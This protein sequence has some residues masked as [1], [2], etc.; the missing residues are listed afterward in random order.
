MFIRDVI[1]EKIRELRLTHGYSQQEVADALFMSQNSYSEFECG[2]RK[3]D[4]ERLFEM[5]VFFEVS[6]S[7]FLQ[8]HPLS[9]VHSEQMDDGRGVFSLK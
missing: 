2:K 7:Y 5:A 9:D 1:C 8:T 6:I 3:L 4:V